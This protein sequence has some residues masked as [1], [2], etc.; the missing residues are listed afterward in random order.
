[1]TDYLQNT[2][3]YKMYY[4]D[5]ISDTE[6]LYK[7]KEGNTILRNVE[8]GTTKD[9]LNKTTL[10]SVNATYAF[11][12]HDLKYA[13]LQCN[14]VKVW[15]YSYTATFHIYDLKQS[16][17]ITENPL[18][19]KIQN[20]VWSPVGH[21][22]AY[23]WKNN[24]FL[25]LEPNSPSVQVTKNGEYNKIY[26]GIPD[27]VYEEEMFGS[28]NALWWSPSARFVAYAEFNDTD[29]PAIEYSFYGDMQYPET[30]HIPY[31]KAGSNNPIVRVFVVDSQNVM[32]TSVRE[33][34]VPSMLASSDH[35]LSWVTWVTDE[36]ISVK[37]V[38]R[39][40]NVSMLAIYDLK[41]NSNWE[42]PQ[43]QQHI[44]TSKTGWIGVFFPSVPWFSSDNVSYY[45]IFSD[46]AGY[47]HIYYINGSMENAVPLT[48]GKWEVIYIV[49]LTDDSLYYISNEFQDRPS[50]R[51]IFKLNLKK[52]NPKAECITCILRDERCKYYTAS[53]SKFGKYYILN[54][55]GPGVPIFTLHHSKDNK[56]LEILED[57]KNLTELLKRYHMPTVE[58][59][60]IEVNGL[61]LWYQMILPP[62]FDKRKKY[63]LLIYTYAGPG[64]QLVR[65]TYLNTWEVYLA[66]TEGIIV[67]SVDGRGSSNRG[68]HIMHAVYRRLGTYEIEDQISATKKFI[69]M[70]FIDKEKVAIW[71]W[72][73]G[74]Y[75]TSLA[76]SAG[77]GVFKCGM[78]VA[79]V[80]DW[81][82]YASI[83]T[84]RYMGLPT[85]SDN[86]EAYEN[87]T[88]MSRAQNF[89]MVDYLLIH[90]TADD[91]VHFQQAAQISKALVEA[92][93]DFQAMWYTDKDHGLP[94]LALN[95]VYIHMTH[96]L[97]QCFLLH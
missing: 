15:R 26:N 34:Q 54:C 37:W 17:F 44:E 32:E 49:M 36:R 94:G 9:I 87:S 79:P 84:E 50:T 24:V 13:L 75:V 97:K 2:L 64:T 38:K 95:H 39:I 21:K 52:N 63:P 81:R 67:A 23:V 35:Y 76:L 51:H 20:I 83:Y 25:K 93:V 73:Y 43:N 29:V 40:Q 33:I 31:P 92:Q 4:V 45:E 68:D 48:T 91:N 86:L 57:N 46:K 66:S 19:T 62:N 11:F 89:R 42:C 18:P 1:M 72:S 47:K 59:N 74:G 27:W 7:T 61:T 88:V 8:S 22:L 58:R 14:Y 3:G 70:G 6:Y 16:V 10:D 5:W 41:E 69:E 80:S 71:G 53:F 30:I 78:A 77:T 60:T 28:S 65:E 85:E 82:Y 55:Y 12:S 56:E 96:F 90:G